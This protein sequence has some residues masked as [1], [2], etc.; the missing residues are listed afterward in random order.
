MWVFTEMG[1]AVG[2]SGDES[3]AENPCCA[4]ANKEDVI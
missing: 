2:V 4:H 1:C 3:L